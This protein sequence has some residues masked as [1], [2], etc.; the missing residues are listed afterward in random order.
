MNMVMP[1]EVGLSSARLERLRAVMQGYVDQGALAGL[2]TLVA[3]RGKVAH[4][5]CFGMMDIEAGKPMRPDTIFRIYSMT[6][7]ITC[8]A[9][10][11]LFEEGRVLL[12]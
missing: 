8:V 4:F 11:M 10:M 5:E 7:P 2:I 1:E 3:R 12:S 9:F 6:R